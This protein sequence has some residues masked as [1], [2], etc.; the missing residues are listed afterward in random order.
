MTVRT[1]YSVSAIY[2][3]RRTRVTVEERAERIRL[4]LARITDVPELTP[5]EARELARGL[6][7]LAR[8]VEK[9]LVQESNAASAEASPVPESRDEAREEGQAAP[10]AAVGPDGQHL[11]EEAG[12]AERGP[13]HGAAGVAGAMMVSA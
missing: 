12:V 3:A 7:Q 1:H 10:H 9:R 4:T 8:R 2:D 13:E 5:T 11:H 6:Y